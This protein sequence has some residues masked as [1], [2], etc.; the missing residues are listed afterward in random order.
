MYTYFAREK[1]LACET[2]CQMLPSL[3]NYEC[4][5]KLLCIESVTDNSLTNHVAKYIQVMNMS[6]AEFF[7]TD[8]E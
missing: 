6:V 8:A 2:Q 1:C 4:S 3:E 7:G 5:E